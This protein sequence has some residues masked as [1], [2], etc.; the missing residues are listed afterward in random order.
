M[1][2]FLKLAAITLAGL[3]CGAVLV[4]AY[5]V[6]TG[7][8]L[9]NIPNPGALEASGPVFTDQVA[10]PD[11]LIIPKIGVDAHIKAV[12]VDADGNMATPGNAV[13]TA[14]YRHGPHPGMAGSAVV[15]GHLNTRY[16][17]QAVF[18]ELDKLEVGDEVRLR[19]AD[20]QELVFKV[21]DIRSLAHDAD[22]AEVFGTA[23]KMRD[24]P[25]RLN[26]VTCAGDWVA[27]KRVYDQR[28]VVFTE[29]VE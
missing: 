12:G 27:A 22:A 24:G 13:D 5:N 9:V 20:G 7:R 8:M 11:R 19:A 29:R 1:R 17:E 2:N 10:A 14:W 3:A 6:V 4:L 18:Y 15:S 26:L 28:L 21:T 23:N 25:P 16:V